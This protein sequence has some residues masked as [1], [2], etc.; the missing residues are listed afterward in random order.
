[1][2]FQ[3]LM[4]ELMNYRSSGMCLSIVTYPST[5]HLVLSAMTTS[6]LT[7]VSDQYELHLELVHN[8]YE[9][10]EQYSVNTFLISCQC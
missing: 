3:V 8:K 2:R 1:M 4:A 9:N 5:A 10:Y 7:V 6:N